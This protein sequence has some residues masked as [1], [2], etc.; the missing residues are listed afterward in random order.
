[1]NVS[2]FEEFSKMN[3]DNCRVIVNWLAA[4][5]EDS[6]LKKATA[7]AFQTTI[8]QE[9]NPWLFFSIAYL[10]MLSVA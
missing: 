9:I 3:F 6:R 1:M 2:F 4:G 10:T 8:R 7:L 5:V